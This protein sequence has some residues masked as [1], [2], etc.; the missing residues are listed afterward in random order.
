MLCMFY[1]IILYK[2]FMKDLFMLVK[3]MYWLKQ[4]S[5]KFSKYAK[6]FTVKLSNLM[7][8]NSI[9]N[10]EKDRPNIIELRALFALKSIETNGLFGVAS[11]IR[12]NRSKKNF[13]KRQK[14]LILFSRTQLSEPN[15]IESNSKYALKSR[16]SL[17]SF[18]EIFSSY[19]SLL[20]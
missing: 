11:L 1:T 13:K 12:S 18:F 8:R 20:F 16:D 9:Q 6:L 2:Y 17:F 15:P 5:F 10:V 14:N 3:F 4:K 19:L 7:C